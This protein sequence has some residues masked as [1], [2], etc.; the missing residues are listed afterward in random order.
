MRIQNSQTGFTLIELLI[1]TLLLSML[2]FA[3]NYSYSMFTRKWQSE[4]GQFQQA[5]IQ[6]MGFVRLQKILTN[7]SPYVIRKDNNQPGFFFIGGADSLLAI[8]HDGMFTPNSAEAF[9]LSSVK[10][11]DGTYQLLYQARAMA[12]GSIL[13]ESQSIEFSDEIVLVDQL[14]KISFRYYGWSSYTDKISQTA[15]NLVG[16]VSWYSVFS[17]IDKQITPERI[18]VELSQGKKKIP[19][20]VNLD[21]NADRWLSSYF[22]DSQYE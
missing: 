15:D 8:T 16:G 4:L 14:D 11:A 1:V 6:A 20:L 2:M 9:R 22:D 10:A 7:I 19:I 18:M 3:G 21:N 17:G 13:N 12:K 5:N